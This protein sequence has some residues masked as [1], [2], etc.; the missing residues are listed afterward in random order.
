MKLELDSNL[1]SVG[2]FLIVDGYSAS[3][4]L[5]LSTILQTLH[6]VE[7]MEINNLIQQLS[8][9]KM[10]NKISSDGYKAIIKNHID[11]SI[12]NILLSRSQNFRPFDGSSVFNTFTK[13]K[14]LKRLF[15]KEG[16]YI[17]KI[18]LKEKPII[19]FLTHYSYFSS[20]DL[21]KI[22]DGNLLFISMVRHPVYSFKHMLYLVKNIIS[23]NKRISYI[24]FNNKKKNFI[25]PWFMNFKYDDSDTVTDIVIKYFLHLKS[26]ELNFD[27]NNPRNKNIIKIPFE[28]FIMNTDKYIFNISQKLDTIKTK[29]TKLVLKKENLPSKFFSSREQS[30][31]LYK[32]IV[33]KYDKETQFNYEKKLL[34]I[35]KDSSKKNF[36][37][38]I[39]LLIDYEREHNIEYID[40]SKFLC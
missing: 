22:L 12:Q 2:K 31:S 36:E 30:N 11:I 28:K 1:R 18:L 8:Y 33:S 15:S 25:D 3:G 7:K 14:Y 23:G 20:I 9:L 17:N 40:S 26:L 35:K 4:K 37:K 39:N 27:R 34:K 24:G 10:F 5:L 38:F 16:D 29:N 6:R 32:K 21:M 19:H 13:V